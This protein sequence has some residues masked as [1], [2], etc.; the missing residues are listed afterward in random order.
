MD[1]ISDSKG[2]FLLIH[3]KFDNTELV[4][5]NVYMPTKDKKREKLDLL[6]YVND[7]LLRFIDKQII[8]GKDFNTYLKPEIDK[9]GG[10][11]EEI[12]ET[13]KNLLNI[14]N[15]FDLFDVYRFQNPKGRLYTWH[16]R[17][18]SGLVQSRLDMFLVNFK[19]LPGILSDHNLIQ[20]EFD[21]DRTLIRGRG[22]WKF[23]VQ[24]LK[25]LDY[26]NLINS[27]ISNIEKEDNIQDK[28]LLWNFIKCRLRGKTISYAA[29]K[30]KQQR[31]RE[32][33]L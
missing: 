10:Q 6:L 11:K 9:Y 18:R 16:N 23:N 27:E 13:G 24:L 28:S 3:L 12:S 19:S 30:T 31:A 32:R 1:Q 7:N 2:R 4:L 29:Y 15:T 17:G 25:D 33:D 22:F 14:L 20:I 26:V 8:L 21:K 5:V